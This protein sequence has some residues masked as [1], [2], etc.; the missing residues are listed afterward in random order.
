ML[1][2]L[3]RMDFKTSSAHWKH[4][5]GLWLQ[6]GL[7]SLATT[8]RSQKI[9]LCRKIKCC[10]SF[11]CTS[12]ALFKKR[13]LEHTQYF[14]GRS[15]TIWLMSSALRVEITLRRQREQLLICGVSFSFLFL[16][17][18]VMFDVGLFVPCAFCVYF[19]WQFSD[20]QKGQRMQVLNS[21]GVERPTRLSSFNNPSL[22]GPDYFTTGEILEAQRGKV[23]CS[24]PHTTGKCILQLQG[25][26]AARVDVHRSKP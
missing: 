23:S 15:H 18:H 3:R 11:L 8:F 14:G 7:P 6:Q 12:G 17:V 5:S 16:I 20:F 21:M 1:G 10:S 2:S 13:I 24:R 19:S 4:S 22:N 9:E 25:V 26:I